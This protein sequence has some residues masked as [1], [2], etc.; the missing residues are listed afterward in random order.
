MAFAS[1]RTFLAGLGGAA[2]MALLAACGQAQPTPAPAKPTE[3]PKPAAP[4]PAAA[5][6]KPAAAAPAEPTKPAA[7]PEPTKPAA[8]AATPVPAAKPAAAK[9]LV[10]IKSHEFQ[11]ARI[12]WMEKRAGVFAQENPGLKWEIDAIPEADY[13]VKIYALAATKTIGDMVNVQPNEI[14]EHRAKGVISQPLDDL[15]AADKYDTSVFFPSVIKAM[16][17]EGKV[18]GLPYAVAFGTNVYYYNEDLLKTMG[19]PLPSLEWTVDNLLEIAQK[20]TKAPEQW[21]FRTAASHEQATPYWLRTFG[22]DLYSAD[23]KKS[24]INDPNS[25][26]GIKWLYDLVHTHKVAP[27]LTTSQ[28][29]QTFVAGKL[30][31]Y[32]TTPGGVATYTANKPPFKWGA[33]VPPKGPGGKRGSI[34]N[35]SGRPITANSQHRAET[36]Q[37]IKFLGTKEEG[38]GHVMGGASSPGARRDVWLSP[39]LG[40]VSPIFKQMID[41]VGDGELWHYP[42]NNRNQ[43]ATSVMTNSM[44]AIWVKKVPL[45]EG[46]QQAHAAV[47]AVLDKPPA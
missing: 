4:A 21:G 39:E 25:A 26:K 17:R 22:G 38:I 24:L 35:V 31:M 27:D 43:E 30:A 28:A 11:G 6:T 23:G 33:M 18:W 1:R 41:T 3:A 7:A 19:A 32:A 40:E 44:D 13:Y 29:A 8:A 34:L 15:I 5:P 42:A 36:F 46:I 20:A 16:T 45:E 10:T 37:L 14:E 9:Q 47:Q 12:N 2:G